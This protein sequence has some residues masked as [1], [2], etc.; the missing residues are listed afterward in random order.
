MK[1]RATMA[2]KRGSRTAQRSKRVKDLRVK[3]TTARQAKTVKGGSPTIEIKDF[4]FGVENP[5]NIGSSTQGTGAG[6]V[7]FGEFNIKKP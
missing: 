6:K 7:S 2:T 4:S 3:G 1:G 5:T